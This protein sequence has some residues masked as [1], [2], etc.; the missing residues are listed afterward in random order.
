M[1]V[2]GHVLPDA[3]AAVEWLKGYALTPYRRL[4]PVG[5][6]RRIIAEYESAVVAECGEGT[7]FM[8][9]NRM[10]MWADFD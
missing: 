5:L 10:L 7:Y 6:Y 2:Y 1:H 8:P 9:F 4:L 3:L